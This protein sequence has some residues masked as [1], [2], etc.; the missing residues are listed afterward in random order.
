M[1]DGVVNEFG[2]VYVGCLSGDRRDLRRLIL[3]TNLASFCQ[4]PQKQSKD[5]LI[6]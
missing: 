5:V 1:A 4:K 2:Q 3:L 6:T